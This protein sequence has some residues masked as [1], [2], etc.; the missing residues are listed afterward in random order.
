MIQN[1]ALTIVLL[2]ALFLFILACLSLFTPR[3]AVRFLGGFASSA[4]THYFE[5]IVRLIVG[6]AFV[7]YSPSML[8]TKVFLIFGWVIV[9]STIILLL[10]PWRWHHLFGQRFA[11]PVFQH[12]WIIGIGSFIL[13]AFILFSTLTAYSN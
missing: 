4:K 1:I 11:S 10:L 8:F 12:V 3:H 2:S 7:I 13:S 9:G 6:T 5:M